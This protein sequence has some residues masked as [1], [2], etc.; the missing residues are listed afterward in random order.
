MKGNSLMDHHALFTFE[1]NCQEYP[2]Q[3]ALIYLGKSYSYGQ[4]KELSDRFA[5]ALDGLGVRKN[6]K[7]L[8]YL[9]NCVQWVVAYLAILEI[10]A[11]AV[12]VSPIYTPSEIT[13]MINDSGAETI[14]CQDTNFGYVKEVLPKGLFIRVLPTCFPSGSGSWECSL[15]GCRVETSSG[16]NRYILSRS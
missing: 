10:G 3:L 1:Q 16:E 6:D 13:Y 7:V 8:I 4:L 2:D 5:T 14:I 9:P 15:I 11:V 12:P